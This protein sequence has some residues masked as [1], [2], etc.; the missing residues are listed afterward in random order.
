MKFIIASILLTY[1]IINLIV[2]KRNEGAL[3]LIRKYAVKE[4]GWVIP[5]WLMFLL[6]LF[7]AVFLFGFKKIEK[8]ENEMNNLIKEIME[9]N[10]K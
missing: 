3:D 2:I 10:N 5:E 9:E 1:I 7:C 8:N 6:L 4:L